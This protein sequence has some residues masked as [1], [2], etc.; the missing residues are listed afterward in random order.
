MFETRPQGSK[1][2][3]CSTQQYLNFEMLKKE[4]LLKNADILR[5]TTLDVVFVLL[6]NVKMPMIVGILTF[7]SR[8]KLKLR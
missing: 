6:I 7:M 5:L 3:S 8:I 4:K 1:L 2:F